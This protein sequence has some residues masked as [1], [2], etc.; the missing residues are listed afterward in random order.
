MGS[1]LQPTTSFSL[2]LLI[3]VQF[4]GL[5][6]LALVWVEPLFL[7]PLAI[8]LFAEIIASTTFVF[9]KLTHIFV[10]M[11]H[12]IWYPFYLIRLL[13]PV[14]AEKRWETKLN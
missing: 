3:S 10:L 14:T 8:K 1:L 12:Q 4:A 6:S 2:I 13:F 11:V 7:I 5:I 9:Q